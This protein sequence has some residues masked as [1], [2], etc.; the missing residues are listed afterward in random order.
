MDESE[1]YRRLGSLVRQHRKRLD[2][3]QETLG[4]AIGLSR[5]SVANIETGRQ[6]IPLHHLYGLAGALRV[7][8]QA[9]LPSAAGD[10]PPKA[11]R[12]IR[13]SLDLSERQQ[14]AIAQVVDSI[15]LTARRGAG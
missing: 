9:L 5:A 1:I 4:R 15:G 7:D 3:N 2:M 12:E 11:D 10:G 13:S 8:P 6:H 14:A